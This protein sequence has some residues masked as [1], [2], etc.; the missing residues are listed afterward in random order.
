MKKI[1]AIL[2]FTALLVYASGTLVVYK[3]MVY[4]QKQSMK[5]F[6]KANPN[7]SLAVHIKF[8]KTDLSNGQVNFEWVEDN[9]E[10]RFNGEMYDVVSN[11]TFNDSIQIL[12]IKDK[13]ENDLL[14]QYCSVMH[15]QSNKKA[16]VSFLFKL[17]SSVF[18]F[19]NNDVSVVSFLNTE[20][21]FINLETKLS[22]VYTS[23]VTPPP[24]V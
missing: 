3:Y 10:F 18:V 16:S 17:L 8:S 21:P 13:G 23:I 14:Q 4:Q 2:L 1:T 22:K 9:K 19:S 11:S 7:N 15:H 24:Q 20:K 5:A 12:A 6:I